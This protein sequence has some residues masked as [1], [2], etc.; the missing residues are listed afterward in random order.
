MTN[1]CSAS[2]IAGCRFTLYPMTDN[3]VKIITSVLD[4]VNTSNVWMETDDVS[5]CI[6][7]KMVHLFDVT[8]AI[9]LHAATTGEHAAMNGT[10]SIGCPG[11]SEADVY[12]DEIDTPQN[13]AS[14]EKLT[15]RAGCQ[16]SLYPLGRTD[17]MDTIY[18]QID[19]SKH[20]DVKVSHVH[21]ATRLDGEVKDIFHVLQETFD[22]VQESVAH[23]VMT[24]TISANSSS[25][26]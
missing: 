8:Q 2:R 26:A 18:K 16:F 15:Q 20:S 5:T 13:K 4:K 12:L 21:Y 19:L 3:F 25:N 22:R 9:F 1:H 24:F 23:V 6:R 10:F 7:G 17:Y 14:T 11:D